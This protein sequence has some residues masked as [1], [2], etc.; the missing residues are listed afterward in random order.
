[1]A[2]RSARVSQVGWVGLLCNLV[3]AAGKAAAGIAGHS[4]AVLAD[5]LHSLTDSVTDVAVILGVKYWTAPADEDHPHGHGRIETLITVAIGLVV[6]AVAIGM[7]VHAIRG[8]R[9]EALMVPSGVAL[10]VALASIVIKEVLYQWTARVGREVKSPALVANA[11]HHRSDAISSIP[12]A[13]AVGVALIDPEW[14]VVDRVGAV[15]VCLLILQASWRILRPALDQ[16][17]DAGAPA[18]ARKRIEELALEV[19]G[20]EDAHAV[21]TRYVGSELAVDLHVEVDGGLSVGEGHSI[22][23]AVRRKLLED[24]PDVT[25]AVIQIEPHKLPTGS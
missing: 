7:G 21:R 1:M 17:V 15:V 19:D 23:V 14:A 24:G 22:A 11:W 8:L 6:G 20:V 9:S 16:L 12:A 2:S 5:A 4:Q 10:G 18:A 25:D 13:V 3:L